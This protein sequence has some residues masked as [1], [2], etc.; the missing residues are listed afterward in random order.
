MNKLNDQ[1]LFKQEKS[2]YNDHTSRQF[3][4][5][6]E[7]ARREEESK[8]KRVYGDLTKISEKKWRKNQNRSASTDNNIGY[9]VTTINS[10]MVNIKDVKRNLHEELHG[11]SIHNELLNKDII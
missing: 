11:F 4:E 8:K 6:L 7:N 2:I 1:V 3:C 10:S 9:Y 5:R